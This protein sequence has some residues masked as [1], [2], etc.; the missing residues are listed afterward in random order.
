MPNPRLALI[1]PPQSC[2]KPA[3]S[4]FKLTAK[5]V[6]VTDRPF[7][8]TA[9][10]VADRLRNSTSWPFPIVAGGARP[11]GLPVI[12][13]RRASP[14]IA[15]PE[16]YTLRV[17][18]KRITIT[19]STPAG[20]FYGSQTLLQLLPPAIYGETPRPE[21][22]WTVPAVEIEDAP[23]FRWRGV[24]IDSA[25]FFQPIGYLKKFID[26][27]A[28]H[29]LNVFHWHLVDDQGWRIEIKKY[30]RLTTIGSKRRE[31]VRG[32]RTSDL[33]GDGVP[34][35]GFYTQT[36]IRE[37]VAYAAARHVQI[38]PEIEMPGH[39]QAAV[40]AYPELGLLPQAREVSCTW[41][42]HETLFNTKPKTFAFLQDVLTEVIGLFPFEYLHIGGDEA[43]KKQWKEDAKTQAHMHVLGLPD[44]EHLQS[45][46]IRQI[47]EF[48]QMNG[49]RLIG[50]DEIL[51]GG[52]AKS[53]TIM[54]WRGIE[55][56]IAAAKLGNDA[57]MCA[58]PY[59]YFDHYQ[60]ATPAAEPLAIGG[61]LPLEKVHSYEPIPAEL[62]PA[63]E[64]CIIGVQGQLWTEYIPTT[65]HL[66]YMAFPRLCA[67]AE[68]AWSA[69]D[70]PSFP[71]FLG[72]LC[73]H[74][75]RLETQDVRYRGPFES[76]PT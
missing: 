59:L 35:E 36:E 18:A 62:S 9:R 65:S 10:L 29:K 46:F 16:A 47:E 52:L 51:E 5:T 26:L 8:P 70:R 49:R 58:N 68:V 67:L 56:A 23:R 75:R 61:N 24:M 14:A 71:N 19:A 40:A 28:Q 37:L 74:L 42:I 55:G 27:M 7:A 66:E 3:G 50:W 4:A 39:A 76:I 63:Q 57:I 73:H 21:L 13:F 43:V 34:I 48:L 33:G 22:T 60:S 64:R 20:A 25:R 31:T 1:P 11:S 53:A 38:L 32:H 72:R 69:K 44:E 12:E 45:W 30:P 17:T 41:G 54:S 15:N 2:T 6:L